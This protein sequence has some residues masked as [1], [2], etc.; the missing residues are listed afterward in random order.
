MFSWLNSS[1]ITSRRALSFSTLLVAKSATIRLPT[2]P[3]TIKIAIIQ[4]PKRCFFVV[5]GSATF[6]SLSLIILNAN[7]Y[8]AT[9]P[10]F[11][12]AALFKLS[13]ILL[14]SS[15]ANVWWWGCKTTLKVTFLLSLPFSA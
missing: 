3:T 11:S 4:I 15:S 7:P 9:A 5:V 12:W 6:S 10:T 2:V 13:L 1:I 8:I 14:I